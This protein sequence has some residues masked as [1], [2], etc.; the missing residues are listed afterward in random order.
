METGANKATSVGKIENILLMDTYGFL[1][2]YFANII[3]LLQD[4]VLSPDE[5]ER[6]H[7]VTKIWNHFLLPSFPKHFLISLAFFTKN[8]NHI[9]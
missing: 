6:D 7:Q 5:D 4:I 8:H 9:H 1:F 3:H 2:G